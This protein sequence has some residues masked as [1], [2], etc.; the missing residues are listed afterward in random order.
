M[1]KLFFLAIALIGFTSVS[2][3]Q[4]LKFG[5]K[6]GVNFAN[7]DSRFDTDARTG[8]HLGAVAT[9]GLP[10][11]FAIQPEV[12]Y[13]AQGTDDLKVDYINV[14]ILVKY[15]FLKFLSFE[16]GPQFGVVVNDD[17]EV[18]EPESFDVSVAAG[19]GVTFGKFFAQAR[20]NHGLTDVD[21]AISSQNRTFQLSVG[22][23]IF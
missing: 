22:Y 6:G 1:K 5:V 9:I 10:G 8:F 14:P 4:S 13:S 23:Y 20:Y 3:A 16:A 2:N 18:G 12:L 7:I 11:K 19:A 17:Y 15:K 21:D